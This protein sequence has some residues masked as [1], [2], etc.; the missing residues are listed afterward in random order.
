[1]R[2]VRGGIFFGSLI[3]ALGAVAGGGYQYPPEGRNFLWPPPGGVNQSYPLPPPWQAA[4]PGQGSDFSSYGDAPGP[5]P[6][7][8]GY[9]YAPG[10][11]GRYPRGPAWPAAAAPRGLVPPAPPAESRPLERGHPVE[12]V[13]PPGI[14]VDH[15]KQPIYDKPQRGWRPVQQGMTGMAKPKP[16]TQ[17]PQGRSGAQSVPPPEPVLRPQP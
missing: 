16:A 13:P 17:P 11:Y 6:S 4:P 5:A 15:V 7:W 1:M 12:V 9:G 14:P 10:D 8:R 2:G 3:Y